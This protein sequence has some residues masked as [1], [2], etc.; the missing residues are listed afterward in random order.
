VVTHYGHVEPDVLIWAGERSSPGS[1]PM[2]E[3]TRKTCGASLRRAGEDTCPYAN[4]SAGKQKQVS[5]FRHLL[6]R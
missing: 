1:A 3:L 5:V 6:M 4:K 2:S